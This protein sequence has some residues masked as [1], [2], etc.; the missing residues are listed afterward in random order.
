M[1]DTCRFTGIRIVL[2]ESELKCNPA[3]Q[4]MQVCLRAGSLSL[5]QQASS[6]RSSSFDGEMFILDAL[7]ARSVKT[8]IGAREL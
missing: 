3:C 6:F 5:S 4:V 2:S 7:E 8:V 1:S